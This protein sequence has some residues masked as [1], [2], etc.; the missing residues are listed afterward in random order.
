VMSDDS[1]CKSEEFKFPVSR[2]DDQAISSGRPS[3]N[4]SNHPDDMPFR[5][6]AR[7]ISII[8]LDDV[9]IPSG[10]YTIS[11]S[12]YASLH[13]FG[14]LCSPSGNPSVIDQLQILSKF[15]IRE[16]RYIRPDDV[17]S[18]P[19]ARLHKARIAIQISLSGRQTALVRTL[20]QLRWKLPIRLQP[21]GRLPFIVRSHI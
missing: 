4:S 1:A 9:F 15:R 6:D 3:I 7:Q 11:R 21:S 10:P 19:D 18:C 12:F 17:V 16:D 2:P 8:R 20:V 14:R 5:P 13:L